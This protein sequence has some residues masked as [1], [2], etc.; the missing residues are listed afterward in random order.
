MM[1]S[2]RSMTTLRVALIRP[3]ATCFDEQGRM[4]GSLDMPLS[5][6]G[7]KQTESLC[8]ELSGLAFDAI[9]SAP[10][11]SAIQT[12]TCLAEGRELRPKAIDALRN[13]DHGLWHGKLIDEIRRNQPR[14]Y[15]L[16]ADS[17]NEVCPPGGERLVEAQLRVEK[18]IRK[19]LRKHHQ[20]LVALVIPNPLASV[21]A[22]G[23]KD[24]QMPDFWKSETDA[25]NWQLIDLTV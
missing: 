19:L 6:K 10:C 7:Q 4:K 16:F 2:L 22:S 23:W 15:R 8:D 18:A 1:L 11:Q 24:E 3:G 12:A 13:I 20:Q 17:P 14:L 5:E 9:Y 21:L 25:G